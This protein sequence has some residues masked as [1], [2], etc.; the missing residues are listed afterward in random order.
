M[1]GT[2][3]GAPTG[4]DMDVSNAK[5]SE[6]GRT[7]VG[8]GGRSVTQRRATGVEKDLGIRLRVKKQRDQVRAVGDDESGLL[9]RW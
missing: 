8:R 7:D 3:K 6:R 2:K 1:D 5:C 4:V 9:S